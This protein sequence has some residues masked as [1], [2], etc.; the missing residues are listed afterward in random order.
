MKKNFLF[1][2]L[3]IASHALYAQ[4][5]TLTRG[6][7]LAEISGTGTPITGLGYNNSVGPL[8]IGFSFPFFENNYTQF[9][10]ASNGHVSF[11]NNNAALVNAIPESSVPNNVIAFA[12]IAWNATRGTPTLNYFTTGT[13][14]NRILVINFKNVQNSFSNTPGILQMQLYE[15][16]GK[17]EIH[18]TSFSAGP[19]WKATIGIENAAGSLGITNKDLNNKNSLT[20]NNEAIR[21]ERVTQCTGTVS[22]STSSNILCQGS[23]TLTANVSQPGSYSYQWF[24]NS[25]AIAGATNSTYETTIPGIYSVRVSGTNNCISQSDDITLVNSL[26]ATLN[27]DTTYVCNGISVSPSM[28]GNY[29]YQWYKNDV[30]IPGETSASITSQ[31]IGIY[32]VEIT[33]GNCTVV[34]NSAH[35]VTNTVSAYSLNINQCNN[36][37]LGVNLS[38]TPAGITYSWTGPNGF[39]SSENI[40]YIYKA[41]TPH[42]GLYT[43]SVNFGCGDIQ[44]AT[45][46]LT[47]L[48]ISLKPSNNSTFFNCPDK[49]TQ[50]GVNWDSYASL[51]PT[52]SWSGPNNFTSNKRNPSFALMP[53]NIGVYTI[54]VNFGSCGISTATTT[55]AINTP[56][57]YASSSPGLMLCET[58]SIELYTL[59]N[60]S[61]TEDIPGPTTASYS[62][63]GPNNFKSNLRNP[64][65]TNL[66]TA[67]AG[68]Y[69]VTV[70]LSNGCTGTYTSIVGVNVTKNPGLTTRYIA[71]IRCS[72]YQAI[73]APNVNPLGNTTASYL[74][75]GPNGFTSTQL[76]PTVALNNAGGVYTL[77]ATFTGGCTG[78]YT[79]FL[80]IPGS[81]KPELY[82]NNTLSVCKGKQL[83]LNITNLT[84]NNNLVFNWKGP[85]NFSS[86]QAQPEVSANA[87]S[88]MAGVYTLTVIDVSGA[89]PEPF[90]AAI[91]VSVSECRP[92]TLTASNSSSNFYTCPGS[93]VSLFCNLS[94]PTYYNAPSY[95]WSGPNGFTSAEPYPKISNITATGVYTV[96]ATSYE[97][98]GAY[99]A[100]TFVSVNTDTSNPSLLFSTNS[101]C[102]GNLLIFTPT[103]DIASLILYYSITG[104]N[105]YSYYYSPPYT[106]PFGYNGPINA[107]S[108]MSGIYTVNAIYKKICA[109][110]VHEQSVSSNVTV[111]ALPS[112]PTVSGLPTTIEVGE[113]TTLTANGCNGA[114]TILWNNGSSI[115]PLVISPAVSS[116]YWAICSSEGCTSPSSNRVTIALDSC[117]EQFVLVNPTQNYSSGSILKHAKLSNGNITATNF[118]TGN[119]NVIYQ[120]KSILLNAGFKAENGTVFKA[121]IGGCN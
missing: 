108:D 70:S 29:T 81:D 99:T 32:K 48:S 58:N 63:V 26:V 7:P 110:T 90:I 52:Y 113:T 62:W 71:G 14:P 74:W 44:T 53:E 37:G 43:I 33:T 79:S 50:L 115:N 61:S 5:Y 46:E 94:P 104:L 27:K 8:N 121:E 64:T 56:M 120:A 73:I 65:I 25:V 118:V 119:A 97:C 18:Y 3:A 22:V 23:S 42:A 21:F 38:S 89:C 15:T 59:L 100:T 102:E 55:I 112:P 12:A 95:N 6:I 103:T 36:A 11:G 24:K 60:S 69:T 85:N 72:G 88:A 83:K 39:S 40:A 49:T 28:P 80:S 20:L 77:T 107:L 16:S 30:A 111:N 76:S 93:T 1:F 67:D 105:G 87:T 75:T 31:S 17:I 106:P 54:T 13:A 19:Y 96:T 9:Y 57:F 82:L 92:C 98:D 4:S 2:L 41:N 68:F 116:D 10:L 109:N 84:V 45:S 91:S 66:T 35:V 86:T 51:N 78:T 47:I 117:P 34:S 101:F 114:N